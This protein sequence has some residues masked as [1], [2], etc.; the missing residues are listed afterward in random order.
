MCLRFSLPV[1]CLCVSGGKIAQKQLDTE[2]RNF[3][4][5]YEGTRRCRRCDLSDILVVEVFEFKTS[6]IL[7]CLD[8][9][10]MY[11][12]TSRMYSY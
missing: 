11:S 5:R 8:F 9:R 10:Q 7:S 3:A 6:E 4:R 12:N 2:I 1:F